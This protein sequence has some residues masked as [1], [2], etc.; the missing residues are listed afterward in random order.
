MCMGSSRQE[1]G[2]VN[3]TTCDIALI[4]T[5]IRN[6]W[7]GGQSASAPLRNS[8]SD[9]QI[10]YGS[11]GGGRGVACSFSVN[12]I[13]SRYS[14]TFC[15]IYSST[16]ETINLDT[17]V[18]YELY[19][20]DKERISSV[21]HAYK[22]A[23]PSSITC[24]YK[25]DDLRRYFSN[26]WDATQFRF[27]VS[28]H[29]PKNLENPSINTSEHNMIRDSSCNVCCLYHTVEAK[30][31]LREEPQVNCKFA[32]PNHLA[33]SPCF[34]GS[35]QGLSATQSCLSQESRKLIWKLYNQFCWQL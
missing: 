22:I 16:E 1:S 10:R 7:W 34:Y 28:R 24:L 32:N 35:S 23:P 11:R 27:N 9:L 30:R 26:D 8:A 19:E 6:G 21:Q 25:L 29:T 12:I 15:G 20:T 4:W 5:H 17:E 13:I 14:T 33:S 31:R 18:W 3:A 2:K